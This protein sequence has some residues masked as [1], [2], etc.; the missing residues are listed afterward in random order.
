MSFPTFKFEEIINETWEDSELREMFNTTKFMFAVFKEYDGT[1]H[2]D[3][4]KFWNMPIYI[5]DNDVKDVWT[6]TVSIIE[7]GNIVKEVKNGN[8]ITNFPGMSENDYCHVRPHAQNAND[9]Y[10]LPVSDI[11]TGVNEYTKQCFWL[12]NNYILKII[13]EDN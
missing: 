13:N 1:Y 2:F 10:P 12:N 5:L 4:V 8:R 7:T 11:L 6:K 9:T 3:S